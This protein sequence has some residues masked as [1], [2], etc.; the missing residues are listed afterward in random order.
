MGQDIQGMGV[1]KRRKPLNDRYLC[2]AKICFTLTIEFG[3]LCTRDGVSG[4]KDSEA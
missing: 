4:L 3:I 2:L 1:E